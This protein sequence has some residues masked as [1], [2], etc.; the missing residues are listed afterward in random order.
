MWT[1][2]K[3]RAK[4]VPIT[5]TLSTFIF[6]AALRCTDRPYVW[7]VPSAKARSAP[8]VNQEKTHDGGSTEFIPCGAISVRGHAYCFLIG[9]LRA[10]DDVVRSL[11]RMSS[12]LVSVQWRPSNRAR[13]RTMFP[14]SEEP[15]YKIS[16]RI[17]ADILARSPDAVRHVKASSL[18]RL[19]S[20]CGRPLCSSVAVASCRLALR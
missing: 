16:W 20:F 19:D 3:S 14:S 13:E 2:G 9:A 15:Q 18:V 11:P 10:V 4:L 12:S 5:E 1:G 8:P 7:L 6:D 17:P